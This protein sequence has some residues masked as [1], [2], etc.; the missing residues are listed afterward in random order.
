MNI[1]RLL[2]NILD[3][4]SIPEKDLE[5]IKN[6]FKNEI[7]NKYAMLIEMYSNNF[8][9]LIEIVKEKFESLKRNDYKSY[10]AIDKS[11]IRDDIQA[12]IQETINN[13]NNLNKVYFN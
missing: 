1:D 13:F 9:N 7:Q 4:R 5:D 11:K 3:S 2:Q 12:F 6:E 8:N 10:S